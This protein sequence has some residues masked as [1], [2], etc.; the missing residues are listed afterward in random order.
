M[1][2][3]FNVIISDPPWAF[4]DK[5]KKMRAK[6][7]RSADSQ[8]STLTCSEIQDIDVPAIVDDWAVLALW[9]PSILLFDGLAV[10]KAWGFQ[11]KQIFVWTKTKKGKQKKGVQIENP[12]ELLAFGMGRLFRQCHEIALVGT[13]GKVYSHLENKSQRSVTLAPNMGHS[14]KPDS[15]HER[16]ELMF[17]DAKKLE[18]F[19]RRLKEGWTVIGD[20]TCNEDINVSIDRLKG[21]EE[22]KVFE[23]N[24]EENGTI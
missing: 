24:E 17:P 3:K 8:Y 16:L 20:G 5:L 10:M 12:N 15:L 21:E 14:I 19:G 1:G 11:Y 13:K 7:R 6:T 18:M 23:R 9:V 2:E 22:N 4:G